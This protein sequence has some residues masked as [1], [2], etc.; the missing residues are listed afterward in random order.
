MAL[1][2]LEVVVVAAEAV[3]VAVATAARMHMK[4]T[5]GARQ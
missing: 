2:V 4:T 1:S 5:A 3:D